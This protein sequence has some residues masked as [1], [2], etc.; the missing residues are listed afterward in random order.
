MS[1]A[2]DTQ[3]STIN[4]HPDAVIVLANKMNAQGVLNDESKARADKAVDL[5]NERGARCILTS[6]WAYLP[7]SDITIGDAFRRYICEHRGIEADRVLVERHSRDTVGDAYFAKVNFAMPRLWAS[8]VVVTS[9]YHVARS[10]A[11]FEHVFGD[12][13]RVQV[14]GSGSVHSHQS[15][16]PENS[17]QVKDVDHAEAASLAAFEQTMRGV[18]PGDDHAIYTALRHGH[19]FYNGDVYAKI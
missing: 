8:V 14:V 13:V 1:N 9:D 19:P 18:L 15:G 4:L 11:I 17:Q 2:T 6:G 10:R 16:V 5:L 3:Q 12:D 7:G